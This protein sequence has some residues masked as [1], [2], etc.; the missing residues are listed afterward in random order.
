MT[1]TDIQSSHSRLYERKIPDQSF[2]HFLKDHHRAA[3]TLDEGKSIYSHKW[4]EVLFHLN[5]I[6]SRARYSYS[7]LEH[8]VEVNTLYPLELCL[9]QLV[10]FYQCK[11]GFPII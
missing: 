3:L 10:E 5:K 4:S 11:V 2:V 9:Y 8:K 1:S 6:I 7:F